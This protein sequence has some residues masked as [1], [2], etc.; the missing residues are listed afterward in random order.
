MS[1]PGGVVRLRLS[2][3]LAVDTG[4]GAR[5]GRDLGSRKARTLLALLAAARGRTG[6]HRPHRRRAVAGRAARRPAANVA[7]LVSR[8]RRTLGA[9]LVVGLP[10]A[11][12]LGG[13]WSARPRRGASSGAPQAAGRLAAGEHALAESAAAAA[14][15]LLGAE[16]ALLDEDDDDWVLQVRREVDALRRDARHHRVAALLEARPGDGGAGRD[17]RA[18]RRTPTTSGP[19]AT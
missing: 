19:C 15:D 12:A 5:S 3:T 7:T 16:T 18:W 8:V 17:R 9:G 13:A 10:G 1:P 11:Y 14:L 6:R 4:D 2:S